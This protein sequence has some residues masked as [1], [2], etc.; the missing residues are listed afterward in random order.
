LILEYESQIQFY[1]AISLIMAKNTG[2]GHRQGVV[3]NRTQTYNSTTGQY[4]KR[5]GETGRFIGTKETPFKNIR[6]ETAAKETVVKK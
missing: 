3:S 5:D 4:V 2:N 6:K 1:F